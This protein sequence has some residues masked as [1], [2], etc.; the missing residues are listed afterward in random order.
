VVAIGKIPR[1]VV[2]NIF[3]IGM[4]IRSWGLDSGGSMKKFVVA[5][6]AAALLL[7]AGVAGAADGKCYSPA[8]VEAEQALRFLTD[9]MI[10]STEC[11]DQ[12]YGL[13]QQRN[14][15]AVIAYQK[16]MIAH[17]HSTAAF[18]S[19]DTAVA[20]EA[21]MKHVGQSMTQACQQT[22]D[23]IKTAAAL[24]AKGFRAYAASLAAS[25][26]GQYQLCR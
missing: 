18:D 15:D 4:V 14:K 25:A 2:E 20:N 1:S 21:S 8:A 17:F 9:V 12:T 11:H 26:K 5:A 16:A 3:G 10:A 24:D 22:A 23:I 7:P 6:M 13:F 19:W